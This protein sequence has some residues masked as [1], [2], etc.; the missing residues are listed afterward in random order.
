MSRFTAKPKE[1]LFLTPLTRAAQHRSVRLSLKYGEIFTCFPSDKNTPGPGKHTHDNCHKTRQ[2]RAQAS[3]L[4]F[5]T[6]EVYV[7]TLSIGPSTK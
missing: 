2:P 6:M 3:S 1:I 5:H 4:A 7:A